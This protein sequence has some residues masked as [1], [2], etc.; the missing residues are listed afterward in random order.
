MY[1]EPVK[2]YLLGTLDESEAA[3]VERKYFTD[4]A[5]L[6]FARQEERRLIEDYLAHRLPPDEARQFE[7]RYLA[8]PELRARVEELRRPAV[9][10][11]S[12]KQPVL[13]W[14]AVAAMMLIV[15]GGIVFW[16]R[17]GP[18]T[19][20]PATTSRV[21]R[22]LL[23]TATLSPGIFKGEGAAPPG[24]VR[25]AGPGDVKL[26]L[27]L[28]GQSQ[29]VSCAVSVSA[30]T[31]DGKWKAIWSAGQPVLSTASGSGQQIAVVLDSALLPP[32]EYLV[33]ADGAGQPVH[34]SYILRVRPE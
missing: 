22:P 2:A 1:S 30:A 7:L 12:Q 19:P 33:R 23:A 28:P 29:P 11:S 10:V 32:G 5:F 3:E 26:L 16:T 20:Q 13:R 31:A 27:E 14:M 25:P 24:F 21:E 8:V 34:E 15:A 4:H 6:L 17:R 18:D 9:G